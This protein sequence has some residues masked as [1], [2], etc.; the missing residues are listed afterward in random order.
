MRMGARRGRAPIPRSRPLK[1]CSLLD[2]N[3]LTLQYSDSAAGD[4][5]TET[6]YAALVEDKLYDRVIIRT[7]S[8]NEAALDGMWNGIWGVKS[9]SEA[10]ASSFEET[11]HTYSIQFVG[12]QFMNR[13]QYYEAVPFGPQVQEFEEAHRGEGMMTV[14]NDVV[15][16][17]YIEYTNEVTGMPADVPP[18]EEVGRRVSTHVIYLEGGAD[19][20]TDEVYAKIQ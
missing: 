20:A 6:F 18:P 16:I 17:I 14:E 12:D 4:T 1:A 11:R 3:T 10:D 9:V 2:E 19:P 15:A 5:I 13:Y 8:D 7:D